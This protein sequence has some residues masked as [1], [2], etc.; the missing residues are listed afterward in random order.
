MTVSQILR[1]HHNFYLVSKNTNL[2]QTRF[3]LARV[4]FAAQLR[5]R[6]E[7]IKLLLKLASVAWDFLLCSQFALKLIVETQCSACASR[8]LTPRVCCLCCKFVVS[9]PSPS[10]ICEGPVENRANFSKRLVFIHILPNSSSSA[11]L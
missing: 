3:C 8:A 9:A 1:F 10:L 7:S 11:M 6:A 2:N 5:P 4:L